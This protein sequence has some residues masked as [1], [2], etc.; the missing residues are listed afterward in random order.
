MLPRLSAP[1]ITAG[2]CQSVRH[3]CFDLYCQRG[4]VI[5]QVEHQA[6]AFVI[7]DRGGDIQLA[8]GGQD[9]ARRDQVL[10]RFAQA[11]GISGHLQ[12]AG[13]FIRSDLF[14]HVIEAAEVLRFPVAP[15]GKP[16]IGPCLRHARR[17][18]RCR[19]GS[20]GR[21]LYQPG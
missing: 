19:H 17:R 1:G 2:D 20:G 4:G 21:C 13:A 15:S 3:A 7:D 18:L 5:T 12:I 9:A 6:D 11:S 16:F 14:L 10:G 8:M